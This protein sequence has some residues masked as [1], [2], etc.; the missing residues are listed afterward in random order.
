MSISER[1]LAKLRANYEAMDDESLA[2]IAVNRVEDLTEEARL[3]LD[4]V[5]RHRDSEKFRALLDDIEKEPRELPRK[6]DLDVSPS[7]DR[8]HIEERRPEIISDYKKAVIVVRWLAFLPVAWQANVLHNLIL[9][10]MRY[11]ALNSLKGSSQGLFIA[12]GVAGAGGALFCILIG[13]L[14]SPAKGKTWPAIIVA[15]TLLVVQAYALLHWVKFFTD[16]ALRNA[17][18]IDAISGIS[19]CISVS[20]VLLMRL[21]AANSSK[22]MERAV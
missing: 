13:A 4:E 18:A 11:G 7:L 19:T 15:A 14:V 5:T 12:H 10:I 17:V 2:F 8:A 22:S 3:A 6:K 21:W 9:K 16:S 20:A 1:A